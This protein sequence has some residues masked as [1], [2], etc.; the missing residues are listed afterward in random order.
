MLLPHLRLWALAV[1]RACFVLRWLQVLYE[2]PP[3]VD[4]SQAAA[5]VSSTDEDS[6]DAASSKA[7][8]DSSDAALLEAASE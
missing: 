6:S 3:G 2:L 4:I 7:D 5:A 8:E 1:M